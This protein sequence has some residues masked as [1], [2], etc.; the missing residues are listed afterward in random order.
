LRSFEGNSA[1][2]ALEVQIVEA[3]VTCL[4]SCNGNKSDKSPQHDYEY[5]K[6]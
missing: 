3:R 5:S 4:G 2:K 1:L 6:N